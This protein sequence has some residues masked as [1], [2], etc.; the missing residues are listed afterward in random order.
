MIRSIRFVLTVWYV[1]ILT[2]ILC[3]FS[4]VLY[5]ETASNLEREVNELLVSQTDAISE[6]LF[7]FSQAEHEVRK[8]T[9]VDGGTK[10]ASDS[11]AAFEEDIKRGKFPSLIIRWA[12]KTNELEENT[13]RLM[14]PDGAVLASSKSFSA[15]SLPLEAQIWKQALSGKTLY[16]TWRQS[17]GGHFRLVT[18]PVTEDNRVLYIV[19]MAD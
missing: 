18:R 13:L 16:S 4:W 5:S 12:N 2:G 15:L 11:P 7:A 8:R 14:S 6:S 9:P 1:G 17:D 3:L 10:P 19:Q